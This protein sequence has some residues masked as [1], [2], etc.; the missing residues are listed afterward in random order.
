[1]KKSKILNSI[2]I[3]S[4]SIIAIFVMANSKAISS[5]INDIKVKQNNDHN[6]DKYK[7]YY[8]RGVYSIESEMMNGLE[9]RNKRYF[10]IYD[11][12]IF[13]TMNDIDIDDNK[14]IP[15]G[16]YTLETDLGTRIDIAVKNGEIKELKP[17]V[18]EKI[19]KEMFIKEP[20]CLTSKFLYHFYILYTGINSEIFTKNE[21]S[22]RRT[23]IYNIIYKERDYNV[24]NLYLL[25]NK[26]AIIWDGEYGYSDQSTI[27]SDYK[28]NE[29]DC[30]KKIDSTHIAIEDNKLNKCF[31]K[32]K[33][34]TIIN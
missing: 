23:T 2:A 30:F 26:I 1:M 13:T 16:K 6:I 22:D 10:V 25:D 28:N 12:K 15:D 29:I 7:N 18:E 33:N 14:K 11:N 20:N 27:A 9:Q 3:L 24:F 34:C 31:L 19:K 8:L 21:W 32:V 17:L 4:L 5:K